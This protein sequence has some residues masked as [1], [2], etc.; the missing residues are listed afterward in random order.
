MKQRIYD[1]ILAVLREKQSNGD[2][3]PYA[4]SIEV[5]HRLE[6]NAAEVEAIARTIEGIEAGRTAN[7]DYYYE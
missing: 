2:V 3:L 6:T 7:Y 1:T 5:A 4:L